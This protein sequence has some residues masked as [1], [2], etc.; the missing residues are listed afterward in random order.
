MVFHL[1]LQNVD[2]SAR[3]TDHDGHDIIDLSAFNTDGFDVAGDYVGYM[4]ALFGIK[5][6]V[7]AKDGSTNIYLKNKCERVG[8][9]IGSIGS[10]PM[11]YPF[12]T[13]ICI[14]RIK[15]FIYKISRFKPWGYC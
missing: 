1:E 8:S 2:I 3:R 4:M 7:Y 13:S 11:K 6:I 10:S 9:T 14:T 12:E 15:V 5:M